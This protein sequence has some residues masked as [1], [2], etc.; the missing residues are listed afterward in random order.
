[1]ILRWFV[2]YMASD[3]L[4]ATLANAKPCLYSHLGNQQPYLLAQQMKYRYMTAN[5]IYLC[6]SAFQ[7]WIDYEMS[8]HSGSKIYA[9]VVSL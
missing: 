1:M 3:R 5:I 7:Q 2:K 8:L 9:T 6:N 4:S